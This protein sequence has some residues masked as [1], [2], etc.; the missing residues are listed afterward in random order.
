LVAGAR[1][2]EGED[3][4][5]FLEDNLRLAVCGQGVSLAGSSF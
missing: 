1:S 4:L 3:R 5:R 2:G